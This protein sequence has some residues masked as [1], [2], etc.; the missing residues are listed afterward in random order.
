MGIAAVAILVAAASTLGLTP[1]NDRVRQ[2]RTSESTGALVRDVNFVLRMGPERIGREYACAVLTRAT[3][4][5]PRELIVFVTAADAVPA[6]ERLRGDLELPK[7]A[8]IERTSRRFRHAAMTW[9]YRSVVAAMPPGKGRGASAAIGLESPLRRA[10]CPRLAIEI[11]RR[12][13]AAQARERW[14][15]DA[16][17]RYGRDRVVV[18]RVAGP[19]VAQ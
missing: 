4:S 12:G 9:I 19:F 14:G 10:R 2:E 1:G 5:R 13:V 17:R 6:A 18:R 15:A 3:P 11:Q 16:V 7:R 8:R